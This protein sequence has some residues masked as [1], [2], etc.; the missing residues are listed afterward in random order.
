MLA[1]NEKFK[2]NI[3][4]DM[5]IKEMKK[6]AKLNPQYNL[7]S[8]LQSVE[9][10]ILPLLSQELTEVQARRRKKSQASDN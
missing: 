6:L 1:D 9:Q 3:L 8:F 10:T 2:E 7:S 5:F 4:S